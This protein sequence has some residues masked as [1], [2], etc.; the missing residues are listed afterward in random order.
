MENTEIFLLLAIVLALVSLF[1]FFVTIKQGTIG[2][3]TIFGKYRRIL[4]PE[5]NIRIPFIEVVHSC[6]SI[7]NSSENWKFANGKIVYF[8]A[9]EAKPV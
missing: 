6:I 5:L 8:N 2:V 7:K 1:G 4:R 9:L 3:V